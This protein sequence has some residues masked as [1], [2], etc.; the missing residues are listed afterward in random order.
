M[1]F[2]DWRGLEET[3]KLIIEN[4]KSAMDFNAYASSL[5][6]LGRTLF[7]EKLLKFAATK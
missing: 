3:S 7:K 4:E 2:N 1:L 6:F 5:G